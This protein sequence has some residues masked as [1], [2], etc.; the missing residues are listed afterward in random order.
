[1][2]GRA[3]P[4]ALAHPTSY[5]SQRSELEYHAFWVTKYDD[6]ELYSSGHTPRNHPEAKASPSGSSLA[7]LHEVFGTKISSSGTLSA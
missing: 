2:G 4:D 1:M 5:H 6:K 7:L 3:L